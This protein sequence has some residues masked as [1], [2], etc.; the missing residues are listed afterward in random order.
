MNS[1]RLLFAA[2]LALAV[3]AL[4][5]SP[6][7]L[8]DRLLAAHNAERAKLGIAPLR[9]STALEAQARVWADTLARRG[10]FEHSRDRNGAGENL[11]AGTSGY[12]APEAMIGAFIGEKQYFRPGRFPDV[13]SSGRWQD[14]GHYTQLIWPASQQLGCALATG[15]GRDV[16]V[17]RYYPAGNMVGDQ[18]P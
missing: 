4:A 10:T 3:P 1:I 9:W 6:G 11:W 2:L 17:C 8:S 18:V 5:Q 15:G 16:L 13:S 14:V 7:S 12:Y